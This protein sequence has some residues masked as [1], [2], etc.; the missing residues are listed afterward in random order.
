[1]RD[2]AATREDF[3]EAR[4]AWSDVAE[5][6]TR[7]QPVTIPMVALFSLIPFYLVIGD[8]VADGVVYAP[9]LPL[10][11]MVAVEPAWSVVYGSLFCAALMPV[12]V[13][14]QQELVRRTIL[15]F[16]TIWLFAYAVFL[17][18]PTIGPQPDE[19]AGEGFLAWL[20]KVIYASDVRYN[21]FPSLHV[22]QCFLAALACSRVHR[23]LGIAGCAWAFLVGVSTVYTKQH[24]VLDVL[25]GM[26]LAYAAYVIFL[27]GYPREAV[28]EREG[29]LA[30]YLALAA[31]GVYGLFVL[32]LWFIYVL[33]GS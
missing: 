4:L 7:P 9:E 27:R 29:R 28:P 16:L 20:L 12:F 31:F 23:G 5:L 15:A 21:C 33:D 6:M 10:D 24:Y 2:L 13:V 25:G 3:P 22:A 17:V 1:M 8:W 26:L 14:H 19:V 11:R 18:Y 32:G 30:P